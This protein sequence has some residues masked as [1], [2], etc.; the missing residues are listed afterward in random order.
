VTEIY[1]LTGEFYH[2]KKAQI[3]YVNAFP[4]DGIRFGLG[5]LT[6]QLY[7]GKPDLIITGPNVGSE[8]NDVAPMIVFLL[9]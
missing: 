1:T 7:D 6:P 5:T 9:S 2:K 4:A 8:S 3:W